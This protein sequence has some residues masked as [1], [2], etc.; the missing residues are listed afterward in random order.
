[1]SSNI[2]RLDQNFQWGRSPLQSEL[3]RLMGVLE[4]RF[5]SLE[6]HIVDWEAA[7]DAITN[8]GLQRVN[9]T[10]GPLLERLQQAS[11]TGFMVIAANDQPQTLIVDDVLGFQATSDGYQVFQPTEYLLIVDS[12]D[13]TNWGML[14]VQSWVKNTGELSAKVK[15]AAKEQSG[16]S[17]IISCNAA[18]W[19]AMHD[20]LN[21][22][23]A[24]KEAAE[25]AEQTTADQVEILEGLIEV[26]QSG[27]VTSVAGKSGV[28]TLGMAD[29]VGLVTA[30]A[31]KSDVSYVNS[32]AASKQDASAKLSALAGLSWSVD[33]LIYL[34]GAYA[35]ATSAL[36]AFAR[37]L[38]DD[39]DASTALST[40]GV[41]AFIKTLLDD[42]TA[43]DARTTLGLGSASTH[44]DTDFA[45]AST[46]AGYA[47]LASPA[48]TGNPTAPT[49]AAGD[50]DT[51]IAT[52]AFVKNADNFAL[53]SSVTPSVANAV[54]FTNLDSEDLLLTV[55][56]VRSVSAGPYDLGIQISTDNGSNWLF[57]GAIATG[58]TNS[59]SNQCSVTV[60]VIGAKIGFAR[61]MAGAATFGGSGYAAFPNNGV[62][63]SVF[64]AD[65]GA[66]INGVR[67]ILPT[68]GTGL[69]SGN[70]TIVGTV[71][72][73]GR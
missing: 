16:N 20:L 30:L 24:A 67:I 60:S 43:A 7:V 4:P 23:V 37:T 58:L 19:Q 29:I 54:S 10:L 31:T 52:T 45:L 14:E 39:A 8:V 27:P 68:P 55:E 22:A 17:W 48:L 6:R 21:A 46:L 11:D 25:A 9:D 12:D 57:V 36:T 15:F 62:G 41:S 71:A 32:L 49:A 59:T 51:S 40:L 61:F 72:I 5:G 26:L 64:V 35:V 70:F 13:E 66:K 3:R 65:M 18:I 47:P 38:L 56:N 33:K 53:I 1:M 2:E 69:P 44:P 42:A 34:T 73:Y 63:G 28:V 50:N